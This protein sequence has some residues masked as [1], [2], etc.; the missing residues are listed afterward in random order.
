VK[1]VLLDENIPR[2]LARDL[3]EFEVRTVQEEGWSGLT[4]G[5]LTIR[6]SHHVFRRAGIDE[7]VNLQR[8]GR[9]AKPYQVK[10]VRAVVVK[11]RLAGDE[12]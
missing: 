9:H 7:R 11:Y 1:R 5:A 6:G 8:D 10:Q 3:Q 2:T 12:E 4:N